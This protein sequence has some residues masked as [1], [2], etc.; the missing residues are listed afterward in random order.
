MDWN[1]IVGLLGERLTGIKEEVRFRVGGRQFNPVALS[2]L[3]DRR[4]LW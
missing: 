4:A 2:C 3:P 1:E